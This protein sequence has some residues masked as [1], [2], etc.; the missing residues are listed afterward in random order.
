MSFLLANYDTD[1]G[2]VHAH[3]ELLDVRRILLLVDFEFDCLQIGREEV[4]FEIEECDLVPVVEEE[5]SIV[6]LKVVSIVIIPQVN[7]AHDVLQ[8]ACSLIFLISH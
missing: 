4:L 3:T 7:P 5:V 6:D 8:F 2:R 1:G